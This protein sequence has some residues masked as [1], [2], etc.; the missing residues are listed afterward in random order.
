[1]VVQWSEIYQ[2]EHPEVRFNIS[3]GGAGKV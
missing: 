3:A 2:K 1:M